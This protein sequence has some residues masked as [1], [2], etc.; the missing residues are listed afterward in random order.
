MSYPGVIEALNEMHEY[1]LS[2]KKKVA[3]FSV[4]AIALNS[5][6]YRAT[7]TGSTSAVRVRQYIYFAYGPNEGYHEIVGKGEGYI[8]FSNGVADTEASDC[9]IYEVKTKTLEAVI[10]QQITGI[11]KVTGIP[12]NGIQPFQEVV[13][14]TGREDLLLSRRFVREVTAIQLLNL[15]NQVLSIPTTA[16][17]VI[18]ARGTLR[19]RAIN[20]EAYTMI[21]PIWPQGRNNVKISYTAGFDTCP[22][23]IARAI[24]L[25][26]TATMLG[27][28]ASYS[29]GGT[30]LSVT[31]WSKSFG[32]RGKYTEAR[33][34]FAT[35]ARAI[36]SK[37]RTSVVSS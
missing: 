17:E 30:S 7:V 10:Q 14:G 34:D 8:D 2:L 3:G 33:N 12:F 19:V 23:D 4:S 9:I 1:P 35:Q 18:S 36:V 15:P 20:L 16:I 37:Y 5:G 32:P 22:E 27:R 29:G 25:M 26:T 28:E 24:I 6:N 13:D 31:A 21:A 11:E